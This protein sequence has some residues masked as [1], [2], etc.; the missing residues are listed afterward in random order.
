M[1]RITCLFISAFFLAGGIAYAQGEMDA[2]KMS[3]NELNGTARYLGMSGAFGALG[4]DISS[5]S[6]NPAGLGIYRSSE[7]VTTIS[8]S[9]AKTNSDWNGMSVDK[10]KTRFNFDNIAYV[11][12][13]P[14]G[15]DEGIVGWNIGLSYNRVKDFN[16]SYRMNGAQ[17]YSVADYVA[18]LLY[19]T[20]QNDLRYGD[21]NYDPYFDSSISWLGILGF[22]AGFVD[23]YAGNNKEYH[24]AFGHEK[25]GEWLNYSPQNVN[26]LVNEKGSIG[27]YNISFATNISD[28]FFLGATVAITDLDY[29]LS[30]E[31]TEDFTQNSQLRLDNGL[32]TDGTGYAFNI[33]AIVRPVDFLRVGV[34]YN[35]PTWYKMTDYFHGTAGTTINNKD[36]N[37]QNTPDYQSGDYRLRTPDRWIFSIAGV[38]QNFLISAD[39]EL[40][41]YK[42]MVL[43]DVDGYELR[44]TE[45]IKKDFGMSGTLKVGAEYKITPQFSVRAGTLWKTSPMKQHVKDGIPPKNEKGEFEVDAIGIVGTI[46]SYTVDKGTNSYSVGL[47]YRF[48]P[49]FYMDLACVYRVYKED[50]YAFP[51]TYQ[52]GISDI[53]KLLD[54]GVVVKSDP[55]SLKTKTTQVALTLGYKF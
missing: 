20:D 32:S 38:G 48:T 29:T 22:D 44:T 16:R 25:D 47:G 11:G 46:P 12:Y 14:T 2:Y 27:Q 17:A 33:G 51:S 3:R 37:T 19:G 39:Y 5:M 23:N 13:F 50:G 9:S 31:Y 54:E 49:N 8:L 10:S 40:T 30:T 24:S 6:T 7:V 28:R 41:N 43:N 52:A 15:N 1:K 4:G 45:D 21:K 36:W 26:L 18:D 53:N 34:A 42:R 35:S 55:A